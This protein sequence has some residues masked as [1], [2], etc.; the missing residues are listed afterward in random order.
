MLPKGI[1]LLR[2]TFLPNGDF[3]HI[4]LDIEPQVRTIRFRQSPTTYPLSY[5]VDRNYH[6]AFPK[7]RF[8]FWEEGLFAAFVGKTKDGEDA[9][10]IPM[11]PNI[12]PEGRV[13]MGVDAWGKRKFSCSNVEDAIDA[14]GL[15]WASEFDIR[16]PIWH[17]MGHLEEIF[18]CKSPKVFQK[19]QEKTQKDPDFIN[20]VRFID[21]YRICEVWTNGH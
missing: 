20:N 18:G 19:W 4:V 8:G 3:R 14:L 5:C 1:T 16:Q 9:F 21:D 11:L 12:H 6:L 10:F 13:C 17:G 15:F 2:N 7:I